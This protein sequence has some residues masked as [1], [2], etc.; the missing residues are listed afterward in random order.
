MFSRHNKQRVVELHETSPDRSDSF[1][2][3]SIVG[4]NQQMYDAMENFLLGS[5]KEMRLLGE[6]SSL[7]IKGDAAKAAGDNIGARVDYET[8]AKIEIYNQNKDGAS[9]CIAQ[10]EEVSE[11]KH[12]EFQETMLANMDEVLRISKAYQSIAPRLIV[13]A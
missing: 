9:N 2:L 3:K 10:A 1:Q 7:L 8:A 4:D 5:P 13:H 11:S 6:V 12:H